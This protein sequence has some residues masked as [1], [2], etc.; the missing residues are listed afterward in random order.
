M[1][2]FS[3][4]SFKPEQPV[5]RAEFANI[6]QRAFD[7]SK[8]RQAIQFKDLQ[9]GYWAHLAIEQAV[10]MGFMKGYPDK[11]FRP[12]RQISK[13][14]SLVALA[15]GLKLASPASPEPVL[16][17]YQDAGEIPRYAIEEVAAATTAGVVVNHPEPKT[18]NPRQMLTR[19]ET[20]ALIY[21]ALVQTGQAE[22]VSS[23]Y[24]V[25]P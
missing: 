7:R 2:G 6:L 10:G 25:Q 11:A 8:T 23:P 16:N 17:F 9:S 4:N 18:L 13:A 22:Q 15:N 5:T 12:D 20:A 14:E 21:Q 1:E 19:A 3:D 24:I